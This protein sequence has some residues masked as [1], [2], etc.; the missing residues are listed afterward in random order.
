MAA[1]LLQAARAPGSGGCGRSRPSG[2]RR[3]A[4]PAAA[5]VEAA[6]YG[7]HNP[8][9][10]VILLLSGGPGLLGLSYNFILP[11]AA[12]EM[13]IGGDGLGLLLAASGVGGLIAGFTAE[14][15]MRRS[16]TGG[17]SSSASRRRRRDDRRSASRRS[18]AGVGA[19]G[20]RV[21][22]RRLL[23]YS[24]ASLSLVQALSPPALRGRLT[25]LLRCSTGA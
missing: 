7:A 16:V 15:V 22:R 18:R 5:A 13:G 11:V 23:V 21:R 20:H 3:R 19:R 24:A 1:A 14:G 8:T 12:Q 6:S 4:R 2:R 25:S 10:G 17:R 9:L